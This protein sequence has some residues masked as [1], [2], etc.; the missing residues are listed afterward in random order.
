M[1]TRLNNTNQTLQ[2]TML[3]QQTEIF[4]VIGE[5]EDDPTCDF[6]RCYHKF[7]V[8]GKHSHQ[9]EMNCVCRHPRNKALGVNKQ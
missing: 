7:S 5:V 3:S 1:I 8:H 6:S 2:H 4:N 9:K